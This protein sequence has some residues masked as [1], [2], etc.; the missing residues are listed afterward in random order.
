MRAARAVRLVA[1]LL[2]FPFQATTWAEGEEWAAAPKGPTGAPLGTCTGTHGQRMAAV[3]GVGDVVHVGYYDQTDPT[4]PTPGVRGVFVSKRSG[5]SSAAELWRFTRAGSPSFGTCLYAVEVDGVRDV[6]VAGFLATSDGQRQ[7]V[8]KL[9]GN[10]GSVIWEQL[11]APGEDPVAPFSSASDLAVDPLGNVLVIGQVRFGE[12]IV[13]K[14]L[15]TNGIVAWSQPLPGNTAEEFPFAIRVNQAG[16]AVALADVGTNSALFR[17]RNS[18]GAILWTTPWD[19][20]TQ[21]ASGLPE[22]SGFFL[23]PL[24]KA[25]IVGKGVAKFSQTDGSLN[26]QRELAPGLASHAYDAVTA[27]NGDVVVTGSS[28]DDRRIVTARLL[29]ASGA[30]V[31]TQTVPDTDTTRGRQFGQSVRIDS[32][33]DVV[34]GATVVYDAAIGPELLTAKYDGATGGTSLGYPW[35]SKRYPGGGVTSDY[36]S[37]VVLAYPGRIFHVGSYR[38]DPWLR[39]AIIVKFVDAE[40]MPPAVPPP[41]LVGT[42]PRRM[43]FNADGRDDLLWTGGDRYRTWLMQGAGAPVESADLLKDPLGVVRLA[44]DVNG[45]G[46]TDLIFR[47]PDGRHDL[48]TFSGGTQAGFMTLM[49][50][51]SGW[52]MVAVADFDADG[53]QDPLWRHSSGLYG[54]WL[55]CCG[56]GTRNNLAFYPPEAGFEVA[57]AGDFDNNGRADLLW[58][59]PDGRV[60]MELFM[61]DALRT[62]VSRLGPGTGWRPVLLGDFNFDS[63]ADIVWRH[64]NGSYGIWLVDGAT[65]LEARGVLWGGTGWTAASILDL[66]GDGKHDI[67]WAHTNGSEGAWLMDGTSVLAYGSLVGSGSPWSVVGSGDFDGDGMDDL[68][69]RRTDAA[70]GIWFMDGLATKSYSLTRPGSSG[71]EMAP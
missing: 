22:I 52:E 14:Y 45:D 29:S 71:W 3:D 70:Y 62:T 11:G 67:A 16:D 35:W 44:G 15:G 17:L 41:A 24:G 1:F 19:W 23:D 42:L 28:H 7:F 49:P 51:G 13:T 5:G 38:S 10:D 55:D 33:G 6:F 34:I 68:A 12:V 27:S 46:T 64:D 9:S 30:T 57:H 20:S 21:V 39:G 26:W 60:A 69:W 59:H 36:T 2:A 53:A 25:I 65:T 37:R 58:R 50:G 8:A 43:D 48:S 31:W 66:N 61:S 56:S 40:T 63:R 47:Y 4:P 32:I 54:V 18:D